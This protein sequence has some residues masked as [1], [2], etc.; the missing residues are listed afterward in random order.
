MKPD[1]RSVVLSLLA[2]LG[3]I[4]LLLVL[5]F[6][7]YS[8]YDYHEGKCKAGTVELVVSLV[9]TFGSDRPEERSS[10]YYLRV[11]VVGE[12]KDRVVLSEARLTSSESRKNV[13]LGGIKRVEVARQ[14][15]LVPAV[16][17]LAD[18]LRLEYDDYVFEGGVVAES[19]GRNGE[20][21]FTCPLTRN[22]RS[23]WRIPWW[24]ALMSV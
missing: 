7:R 3:A 4:V 16:V 13:D 1:H 8:Y 10:P 11:E 14:G 15:D 19:I 12:K 9:G 18:S 6:D 24:D 23:E 2:S 20:V 22:Y 5:L 21:A 17:Y